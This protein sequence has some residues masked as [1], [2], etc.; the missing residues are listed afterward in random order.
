ME[1]GQNLCIYNVLHIKKGNGTI[2]LEKIKV[3]AITPGTI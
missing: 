2:N 3:T 1:I